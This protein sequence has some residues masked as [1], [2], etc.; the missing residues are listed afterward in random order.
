MSQR[1]LLFIF[2]YPIHQHWSSSCLRVIKGK[3]Y[4]YTGVSC[5]DVHTVDHDLV[6][7]L[8]LKDFPACYPFRSYI[9]KIL[10][11]KIFISFTYRSAAACKI[12]GKSFFFV[13]FACYID[14]YF[15]YLDFSTFIFKH[16]FA[17]AHIWY[18]G[19]GSGGPVGR[20]DGMEIFDVMTRS[21]EVTRYFLSKW[22]FYYISF[23][24]GRGE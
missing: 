9:I 24:G 7:K 19:A 10:F 2:L 13:C 6:P 23:V 4:K 14:I 5:G 17:F 15:Q 21:E 11:T 16:L 22:D 3:T 20:H 12:F 18:H 1:F 8:C